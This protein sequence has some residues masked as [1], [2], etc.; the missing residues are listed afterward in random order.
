MK[1]L[2]AVTEVRRKMGFVGFNRADIEWQTRKIINDNRGVFDA[3]A[4]S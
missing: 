1:F 4:K 3:L 2:E